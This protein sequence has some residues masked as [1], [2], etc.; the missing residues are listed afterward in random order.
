MPQLTASSGCQMIGLCSNCYHLPSHGK[1][2][3]A[4][5]KPCATYLPLAAH[6]TYGCLA[7]VEMSLVCRYVRMAMPVMRIVS[8]G[9]AV[10]PTEQ[11][12]GSYTEQDAQYFFYHY[13]SSSPSARMLQGVLLE[14]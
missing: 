7:L 4:E 1:I 9:V 11:A 10:T 12:H 3:L 2:C 6:T 14:I 8:H 5:S 13:S